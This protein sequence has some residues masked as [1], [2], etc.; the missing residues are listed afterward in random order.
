MTT[1]VNHPHLDA[2]ENAFF[3]RELE[4]ISQEMF[5][6]DYAARRGREL[7]PVSHEIPAG[8]KLHTFRQWDR[9]GIAKVIADYASDIPMADAFGIEVSS[10]IVP[11][12]IGFQYST[13]EIRGSMNAGRRLDLMKAQAAVEGFE[14]KIDKM[15]ALGDTDHGVYGL[16]N[17]PNALNFTIPNGAQ[18]SPLWVNKTSDEI[19]ADCDGLGAYIWRTTKQVERPTDL[20]LSS[21]MFGII[22]S[23]RMSSQTDS[24]ILQ[25]LLK[26]SP[27][28]KRITSW[29]R[30]DGA[31]SGGYDRMLA[32]TPDPS[33]VRLQIPMEQT[34]YAPQ[35]EDLRYKVLTEGECGGVVAYK[36]ASIGY[37][38]GAYLIS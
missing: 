22:S 11:I 29:T 6:V 1:K 15:A 7:V 37:A 12:A 27:Y 16:L 26:N 25:Y 4:H 19:V 34:V 23:K 3:S 8:T 14:D 31:G 21:A 17:Q 33:K 28:F 5:K 20:V 30:L 38:D 10:K 32:F 35:V 18:S 13:Q 24:T 36:P 9:K 2:N